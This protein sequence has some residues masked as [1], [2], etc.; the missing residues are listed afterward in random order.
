MTRGRR[1]TRDLTLRTT[2]LDYTNAANASAV[3]PTET[4][5]IN[6]GPAQAHTSC[7]ISTTELVPTSGGAKKY[8]AY[9]YSSIDG[10]RVGDGG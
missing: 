4:F 2:P 10:L 3:L 6:G 8:V 9:V 5:T 7:L 1:Q